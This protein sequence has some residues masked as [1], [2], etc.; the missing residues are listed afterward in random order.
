MRAGGGVVGG[1]WVGG[2]VVV[3]VVGGGGRGG[4][5]VHFRKVSINE[6]IER[7]SYHKHKNNGGGRAFAEQRSKLSDRFR[8]PRWIAV[9]DIYCPRKSC[10]AAAIAKSSRELAD[11]RR[12]RSLERPLSLH[13][14]PQL[15]GGP[16]YQ[17]RCLQRRLRLAGFGGGGRGGRRIEG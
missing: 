5:C 3:V 12:S 16:S 8:A 15:C 9:K 13:P 10:E 2:W 6:V 4:G 7:Q 17:V 11:V 14:G 1:G